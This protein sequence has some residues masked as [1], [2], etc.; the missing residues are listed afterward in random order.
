MV[1]I[2][3]TTVKTGVLYFFSFWESNQFSMRTDV[4]LQLLLCPFEG[5]PGIPLGQN[6][7]SE[8]SMLLATLGAKEI[9]SLS[10]VKT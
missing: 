1:A 4:P 6:R 5:S 2:S 3:K 10:K 8:V 9:L 7:L